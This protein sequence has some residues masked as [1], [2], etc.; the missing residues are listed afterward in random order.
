[1]SWL[2]SI[3]YS[4][5]TSGHRHLQCL[6]WLVSI[7]CSQPV[8]GTPPFAVRLSW[9]VSVHFS[10]PTSRTLPFAVF[11]MHSVYS[12]QPGYLSTATICSVCHGW[13]LFTEASQPSGHR[14]ISSVCFLVAGS[15]TSQKH[16]GA[17]CGLTY[18][19]NCTCGHTEIGAAD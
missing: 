1:M 13:C 10:Q 16:V 18:S 17:P 15:L 11:V 9:L 12:L 8:S 4:Q 5:P 7:H 19:D 3:H 6:S 2:V 14:N